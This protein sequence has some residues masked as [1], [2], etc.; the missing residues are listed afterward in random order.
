ML[1]MTVKGF[2]STS[3][4]TLLSFSIFASANAS[5]IKKSTSG[6]CHDVA[7]PSYARTKNFTSYDS[8][9]ACLDSGGRLPK[10]AARTKT[11]AHSL[12]D[13]SKQYARHEF[14]HGWADMNGDC[15][16]ARAEALVAQSVAPVRF[17]TDKEC[18][19]IAGRWNSTF[20]GNTIYDAADIDIDHVVPLRWA[21]SRGAKTWDREKRVQFANDQA[22]LLAVEASLNRQKGAKGLDEWLPPKNQCQYIS[23]F[24]RI[25]KGLWIGSK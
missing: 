11:G 14:G 18:R 5:E 17:Q 9:E 20:T 2:V 3:L 25:K 7:S 19:V 10:N 8:V 6:I 15:R 23:R 24:L 16:N 4:L 21:W 1:T 12:P 22:N 13:T